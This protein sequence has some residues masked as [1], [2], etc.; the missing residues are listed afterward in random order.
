VT[1]NMNTKGRR[2]SSAAWPARP[3]SSSVRPAARADGIA[4]AFT[5]AG[6]RLAAMARTAAAF[7]EPA[8]TSRNIRTEIAAAAGATVA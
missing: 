3:R 5:E 7:A 2:R 1:G 8:T 4:T 6:A